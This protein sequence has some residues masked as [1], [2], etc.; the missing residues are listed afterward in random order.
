M[1]QAW[2]RMVVT[3]I[4]ATL[5][6]GLVSFSAVT[7]SSHAPRLAAAMCRASIADSPTASAAEARLVSQIPFTSPL[8]QL[9]I[10]LLD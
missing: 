1:R 7:N 8:C 10:E 4:P 5:K 3:L 2:G 9:A 6:S